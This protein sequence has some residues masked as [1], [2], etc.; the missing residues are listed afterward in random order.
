[1]GKT[2]SEIYLPFFVDSENVIFWTVKR[3]VQP[4]GKKKTLQLFVRGTDGGSG[5]KTLF[6]AIIPLRP[7]LSDR[8]HYQSTTSILRARPVHTQAW[9]KAGK[10]VLL[11]F[12]KF[13]LSVQN[14]WQTECLHNS[15]DNLVKDVYFI[16]R[17]RSQGKRIWHVLEFISR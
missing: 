15:Q 7:Q 11:I 9:K 3:H 16:C 2:V 13:L 6:L 17:W 14:V 4:R 8:A 12:V 5:E 1:M 10:V